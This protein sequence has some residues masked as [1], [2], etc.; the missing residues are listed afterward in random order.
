MRT[1]ARI[2][3]ALALPGLLLLGCGDG[4]ADGGD[5]KKSSASAESAVAA[6]FDALADGDHAKACDLLTDEYREKTVGDWNAMAESE[7]SSCEEALASSIEMLESFAGDLEE[8]ASL[9]DYEGLEVTEDGDAATATLQVPAIGEE[10][11]TY[12]LTK[13]DGAWLVSGDE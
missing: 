1:S 11:V 13:V 6:Y 10:P 8:G 4:D 9:F 5:D 7:S 2:A 12:L 3:T